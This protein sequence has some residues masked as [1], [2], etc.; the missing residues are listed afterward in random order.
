MK[1][2]LTMLALATAL[3]APAL[4]H[5]ADAPGNWLVRGRI[6]DVAPEKGG[7]TSLGGKPSAGDGASAE[8]DLTYFF[9]P[10]WAV[11]GIAGTTQ[12]S[13]KIKDRPAGQLDLGTVRLLPPTVTGQYH[14]TEVAGQ[15]LGQFKPY[16]GAGLTYAHF[17][18]T[19]HP[20]YGSVKYDDSWG[21]ALQ[22]GVDYRICNTN[23]YVN[24]D[25][26]KIWV[27]SDVTVNNTIKAKAKLDPVVWG[28]G[29]GYRF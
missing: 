5:A 8:V 12:H 24:G 25:V 16:V 6:I 13:V 20:G 17:Y 28:A 3:V 18:D 21:P 23:W 22:A 26:K 7:Y 14:F 29:I 11:E 9:T 15:N 10:N 19:E 27:S 1:N 2:V 4:V